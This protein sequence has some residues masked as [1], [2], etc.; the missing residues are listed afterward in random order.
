MLDRQRHYVGFFAKVTHANFREFLGDSLVDFPVA[1]R[2]PGWVNGGRQRV[3]KRMHIRGIHIVFFIPGG[4]RQHDVGVQTGARQTEVQGDD[5][6]QLAVQSVILPFHFFWLHAPLFT[7]IQPLNTMFSTQQILQ[8]VLVAFTGRAEQVRTPDKQVTRMVF[9]VLWLFSR[10]A[11]RT[12]LQRFNGVIH[13]C[14]PDFFRLTRNVQRVSTQLR[15]RWQPA[16]TFSAYVKV[17]QMATIAGFVCHRGQQFLCRNRLIA[18]LAGVVIEVGRTVHVT[19]RTLPVKGKRQRLPA[20][21]RTQF[22][23]AHV[24]RPAA[25]ALTDAAAEHQHV[26]QTTIVHIEVVPVVQTRADNNH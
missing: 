18:P 22:F 3:N 20:G 4:G 5:Q 24:V 12:F 1:L 6:I 26:N 9:T 17:N 21:L 16:H 25:A 14:H 8:H 23:L 11:N 13:R 10:K 2:F 15:R 7:Q 19:R